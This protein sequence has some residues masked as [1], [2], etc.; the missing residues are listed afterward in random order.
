MKSKF[1]WL[2]VA[3]AAFVLV[4]RGIA[5]TAGQGPTQGRWHP[6]GETADPHKVLEVAF[7]LTPEGTLKPSS[8]WEHD[9][10]KILDAPSEEELEARLRKE[11]MSDLDPDS[12]TIGVRVYDPRGKVIYRTAGSLE[13]VH[14]SSNGR[15]HIRPYLIITLPAEI[16]G[17]I[18]TEAV[19]ARWDISLEIDGVRNE[20]LP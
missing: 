14:K 20:F 7:D 1:V 17:R 16:R 19:D 3:V 18:E 12:R 4:G 15:N 2:A 11:S 13:F 5:A 6:P 10:W 8:A 9:S